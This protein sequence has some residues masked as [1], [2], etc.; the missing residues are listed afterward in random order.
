MMALSCS[1]RLSALL[2]RI[3]S[4]NRGEF[5]CLNCLN[6]FITGNKLKSH[7]KVCKN[8]YFCGTAMP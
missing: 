2:H 1:K 5:Y 6:S 4:K 7:E 8:K 3:T